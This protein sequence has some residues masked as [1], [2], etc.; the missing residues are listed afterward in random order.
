MTPTTVL[1]DT[2]ADFSAPVKRNL[3]LA[4]P[5]VAAHE[6]KLRDVFTVYDRSNTDL[7]MLD[8]LSA[9]FVSLPNAT[10]DVVLVLSDADGSR[11]AESTQL[12]NRHL[13]TTLVPSIKPG[14]K[15]R[16]QDGQASAA[17]SREAILA[18]LV[19]K[20]DGFEKQDDEE[21][22]VPLR[23]GKKN[24]SQAP[25]ATPKLD[26]S[27]LDDGNDDDELIDEDQLLDEEDLK[28][29]PQAPTDCQPQKRRRPCKDCTC[30]L[31]AKFEAEEKE[32][33][34]Q[35]DANLEAIK[36]DSNDLNE[37]DFTVKGKTGSCNNC[38]L[39]DAFRCSTCPFIGLP[40]F[41]PGEEVR[42]MNEVQL[43]QKVNSADEP[44][45]SKL[46]P[47]H[48]PP[49]QLH[50]HHRDQVSFPPYPPRTPHPREIAS[51]K[52]NN[53]QAP[54]GLPNSTPQLLSKGST[55]K[56]RTMP[57]EEYQVPTA[58]PGAAARGNTREAHT[59][60]SIMTYLCGDCGSSVSLGKDALVACPH[61]AGR[62]L[63]KERTKRM[64]Q[65]EA[66]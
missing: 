39:G 46:S 17:E 56:T 42:I 61:C 47:V 5:S 37:L 7:Q 32:R 59:S 9:G 34:A 57:R 28:R 27:T 21:V 4:P 3:L 53:L 8:R 10:Y 41:K 24:K 44:P 43:I 13:F 51:Q 55:Q 35:A 65:F 16:F 29:R 31:A 22:V 26:L 23:F 12:L 45:E 49:F 50:N 62:V 66:R 63:Y 19:A 1:V 15:L 18:G 40:A 11:G 30:G 33:R 54:K 14:G 52:N 20:E 25:A 38:S 60:R 6:E 64:V 48:S 2:T 58:A 36:L